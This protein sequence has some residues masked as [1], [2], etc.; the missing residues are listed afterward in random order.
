MKNY[1]VRFCF[2][3]L[4]TVTNMAMAM[5]NELLDVPVYIKNS[6]AGLVNTYDI[7]VQMV[8]T[9]KASRSFLYSESLVHYDEIHAIGMLTN[10]DAIKIRGSSAMSGWSYSRACLDKA[11]EEL[12]SHCGK[13]LAG[14][15]SLQLIVTAGVIGFYI[16][17]YNWVPNE[18]PRSSSGTK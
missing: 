17:Y 14:N 6:S 1:P 16:S 2:L 3:M 8:P 12:K 9:L 4:F 5:Q 10:I 13:S 11:K 18:N 7:Y 15:S